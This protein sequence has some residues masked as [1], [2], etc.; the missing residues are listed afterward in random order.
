METV[1]CRAVADPGEATAPALI[2]DQTEV[3]RAEKNFILRLPPPPSLSQGLD[4]AARIILDLPHAHL[5]MMLQRNYIG[6]HY[7]AEEPS[8]ASFLFINQLITFFLMP[9]NLV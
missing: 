9:F 6:N 4:K 8:T 3:R 7:C 5:L 2:L 1:I